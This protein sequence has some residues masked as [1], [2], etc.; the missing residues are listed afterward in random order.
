M[1]GTEVKLEVYEI[2]HRMHFELQVERAP[3]S[4]LVTLPL[5]TLN[6]NYT[7]YTILFLSGHH[8]VDKE[9]FQQQHLEDLAH[10][11]HASTN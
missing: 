3:K 6:P 1:F 9:T 8:E 10:R 2:Y 5:M 11:L 4:K 7:P